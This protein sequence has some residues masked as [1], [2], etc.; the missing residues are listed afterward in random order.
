MN[1][2]CRIVRVR[3]K[4]GGA[5]VRVLRSREPTKA[6][7][8]LKAFVVN[9]LDDGPPPDAVA[10]VAWWRDPDGS[11]APWVSTAQQTDCP[12]F[13][14]SILGDLAREELKRARNRDDAEDRVM[15]TLGYRRDDDP[16]GAA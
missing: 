4:A 3:M 9:V 7:L 14:Y 1:A 13:P 15:R 12:D 8:A 16:D 5:D 6:V 11:A 10:C 2:H